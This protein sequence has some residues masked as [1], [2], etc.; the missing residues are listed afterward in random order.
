MRLALFN[1]LQIR[2]SATHAFLYSSLERSRSG[3]HRLRTGLPALPADADKQ[4]ASPDPVA[5]KPSLALGSGS[6]WKSGA[7]IHEGIKRYRKCLFLL[8]LMLALKFAMSNF[9][10]RR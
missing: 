4:K 7:G 3:W 9:F 8:L 10:T 6:L 1:A 2:A 5:L